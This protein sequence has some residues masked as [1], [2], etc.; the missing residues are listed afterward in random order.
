MNR[1]QALKQILEF[2][3]EREQAFSAL[4][5]FAWDPDFCAVKVSTDNL[6]LV[7]TKYIDGEIT[8]EQLEQWANIIECR[9]EFDYSAIEGYIYALAEPEQMGEISQD[10]IAK[11]LAVLS[12]G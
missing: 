12:V 2:G 9:D 11:M 1:Q 7:L 3:V 8:A 4:V 5:T 10:K 6:A